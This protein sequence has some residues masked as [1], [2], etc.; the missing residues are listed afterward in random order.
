VTDET[1]R[2]AGRIGC[3]VVALAALALVIGLGWWLGQRQ[4][5]AKTPCERYASTMARALDNC[6]SGQAREAAHH[7]AICERSIDP[8]EACLEA[9]ADLPCEELE[10]GPLAAAGEVCRKKEAR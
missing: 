7:I 5:A 1:K 3:A 9:I 8:S 10:R 6:Y 2:G 4:D